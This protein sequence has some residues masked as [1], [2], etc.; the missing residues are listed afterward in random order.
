MTVASDFLFEIGTEEL[1]AKNLLALSQALGNNLQALLEKAELSCGEVKTYVTPRRLAILIHSLALQ[2]ADHFVERKGPAVSAAYD[3]KGNPTQAC[4]GFARSCGVDVSQLQHKKTDK[5]EF[6]YFSYQQKGETA[7]KL[8][9]EFVR[10]AVANL[11][12]PKPMRWNSHSTLFVRPVHW[13]TLLLGSAVIRTEVLGLTSHGH[14]YGHRFLHSQAIPLKSPS[15][16]I[17]KLKTVGKVIADFT[18][19]KES[20]RQ[21]LQDLEKTIGG[22]AIIDEDLLDEVTG[23]VEWPVALLGHFEERFL[24]V[25]APALITA[26]KVHQKCFPVVNNKNQLLPYFITISNIKSKDPKRVISGNERVM[27]ARLSDAA[28]FYHEDL[29]HALKIYLERLDNLVFQNKL[30]SMLDKAKRIALLAKD[31]ANSLTINATLTERAGLLAKA[32]LMTS[33]VSE[34]P[35]LQGIMGRY[36]A[37]HNQEPHE[38]AIAIEEHYLPRF[39]GDLLPQTTMG[40]A[41]AIADRIDTLVGIFGINHPPTGE[42][43][44]FALRR[45]ALSVMRIMIEKKLPLDLKVLINTA[46]QNYQGRLENQNVVTEVFAFMMDRLRAWYAE[47]SINT[48][49]FAAVWANEPTE[50][51]DFHERL[52]AVQHFCS[53]PEA[54]ALIAANKRVSNI[55][56]K[57]NGV[58]I[59]Q[60]VDPG[61]FVEAEEHALADALTEKF[62]ETENCC[63]QKKYSEALVNLAYLQKPVDAFFDKVLVM[64]DDQKLRENRLALLMNLRN[65]F[66]KIADVSL[67]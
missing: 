15:D 45:A 66:L 64:T 18:L 11:P 25:P 51:L 65:L 60:K 31:I 37:L 7:E 9:P 26:M 42:K 23:L 63:Q 43:D 2:Q 13:I 55:L 30:G 47:Q 27:R 40:C 22:R 39:S 33:M 54:A 61:L 46:Q 29:K 1:P 56:K 6:V 44:P 49:T 50:P 28:F 14:T 20:I 5:G 67:L 59:H 24:E 38:V 10:T 4:L 16:Y 41:V 21:Q 8:L 48:E 3:A 57:E 35:E 58:S 19:R 12:I 52:L 17:K 62:R 36:Y 32:D 53:L 34:F